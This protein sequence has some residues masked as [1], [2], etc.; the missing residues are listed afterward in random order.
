MP[1]PEPIPHPRAGAPFGQPGLQ[2]MPGLS[3]EELAAIQ[4]RRDE[5]ERGVRQYREERQ[6]E[7]SA[8]RVR[9][10]VAMRVKLLSSNHA[11]NAWE[12]RNSY[13]LSPVAVAL[14]Y[15]DP[16]PDQTMAIR[17]AG[18]MFPADPDVSDSTRV[19]YGL[20][21]IARGVM[22][23]GQDPRVE[24]SENP[25]AMSPQAVYCGVAVSLLDTPDGLWRDVR[26]T[27]KRPDAIP[28]RCLVYLT[29]TTMMLAD[30]REPH[31]LNHYV[32]TSTRY[33]DAG[34]MADGHQ[35]WHH[36]PGLATSHDDE[37]T[38]AVW[39]CL[40]DLHVALVEGY[41]HGR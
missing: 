15:A 35:R 34:W 10:L 31:S 5:A 32:V 40:Y 17:A 28:G 19:L 1:G 9:G 14:L 33:L 22:A 11:F 30:R 18:R 4:Q 13:G 3:P 26:R 38:R 24:M 25:D 6:A 2:P 8:Q 16:Q 7:L 12:L 20:A 39:T 27:V 41:W 29:D 21:G 37:A 36:Y 23:A